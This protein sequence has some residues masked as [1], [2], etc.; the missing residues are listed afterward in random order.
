MDARHIVNKRNY[1]ALR[2]LP[3]QKQKTN[4]R[5]LVLCCID[6]RFVDDI[7][8]YMNDNGYWNDYDLFTLAGAS[9]GYNVELLPTSNQTHNHERPWTKTFDQTVELAIKLHNIER[10]IVIDHF[11]CQA[12]KTYY[13]LPQEPKSD[14]ISYH[15]NNL[16]R[17]I[18]TLQRR[19]PRNNLGID[20]T[21][22]ALICD[23]DSTMQRIVIDRYEPPFEPQLT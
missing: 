17:C 10:I 9:L 21:F 20:I 14:T 18:M 8:R 4:A 1:L 11:D 13:G 6:F 5:V 12:Y 15:M 19:F 16:K 7:T 23:V 22:E 3:K 2:N